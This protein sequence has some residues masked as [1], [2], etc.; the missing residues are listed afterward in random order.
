[1]G[2]KAFGKTL[3]DW[4]NN[5]EINYKTYWDIIDT[6]DNI[7]KKNR[8]PGTRTNGGWTRPE[9]NYNCPEIF[10]ARFNKDGTI[11]KTYKEI[12]E[13]LSLEIDKAD[14]F[15]HSIILTMI[16]RMMHP[17]RIKQWNKNYKKT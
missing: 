10:C 1:M 16:K 13:D 17:N 6:L 3:S 5:K 8:I 4:N 12:A 9:Y 14:K 7:I 2:K 15:V 11:R